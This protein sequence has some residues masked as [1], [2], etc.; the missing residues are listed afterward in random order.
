MVIE[1]SSEKVN[2]ALFSNKSK[3]FLIIFYCLNLMAVFIINILL[4]ENKF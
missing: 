4:N 3:D 1:G 2:T